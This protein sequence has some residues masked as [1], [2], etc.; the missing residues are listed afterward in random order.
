MVI[1]V[2]GEAVRTERVAHAIEAV[3]VALALVGIPMHLTVREEARLQ[4][5]PQPW[6]TH[7]LVPQSKHRAHH[8]F[9]LF[10]PQKPNLLVVLNSQLAEK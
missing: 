3:H 10:G 2:V 9:L 6:R 5:R 7:V 8:N 1:L 4:Q